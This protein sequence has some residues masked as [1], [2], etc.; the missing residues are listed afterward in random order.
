MA[1]ITNTSTNPNP[2]PEDTDKAPKNFQQGFA[3]GGSGGGEKTDVSRLK[4]VITDKFVRKAIEVG[5]LDQYRAENTESEAV[6]RVSFS[7]AD[8]YSPYLN[9]RFSIQVEPNS[10]LKS[11]I[12]IFESDIGGA[13]PL[14]DVPLI[15]QSLFHLAESIRTFPNVTVEILGNNGLLNSLSLL[16]TPVQDGTE[17]W[18]FFHKSDDSP[19]PPD[20]SQDLRHDI[21]FFYTSVEPALPQS[22]PSQSLGGYVSPTE[23]YASS[24][25]KFSV[26]FYET[27]LE[28]TSSDLTSFDIIQIRDELI[29]IGK[30]DGT[31]AH[32]TERNAYGTPI[33]FHPEGAIVRGL[34]KNNFFNN[35]M[36]KEN[37]QYR[38]I[39]IRNS[40]STEIAKN[41]KVY[42]KLISRNNLSNVRFAIEIPR[43]EYHAG[44][45]SSSGSRTVFKDSSL[46][47]LFSNN[48]YLK[49]PVTFQTGNNTS[50]TRVVV[51][52]I[53]E[54]GE[55]T[56][57]E[58]LPNLTQTGDKYVIDTSPAQRVS[59]GLV[60]PKLVTGSVT[61]APFA[62]SEFSSA[63]FPVNG[64]SINID[65][66]R[67]NGSN[68]HPNEVIYIWLERKIDDSNESFINNRSMVTLLYNRV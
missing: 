35:V 51:G 15:G 17:N 21:K 14:I 57:D 26:P 52:Y 54:T 7:L 32:V 20:A 43:S 62:I 33:R 47:G 63:T 24:S 49:A 46:A 11:F 38:C 27:K 58:N 31:T 1:K 12:G 42:F 39:A 6:M 48:H 61:D 19:D 41:V 37:S 40:S 22:N 55:F 66:K 13:A 23:L 53:G 9:A 44:V 8:A 64:I 65:N 5:D 30:W 68:L 67:K 56:L 50:Q 10:N 36:S 18:S 4:P 3:G 60:S 29:T 34:T 59:S 45:I 2:E 25:L 28:M 16:P